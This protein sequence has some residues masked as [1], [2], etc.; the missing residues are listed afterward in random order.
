MGR[1]KGILAVKTPH[2]VG[3]T[4]FEMANKLYN[5][6]NGFNGVVIYNITTTLTPK[7]CAFGCLILGLWAPLVVGNG[8]GE[9]HSRFGI[10]ENYA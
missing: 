3:L 2:L 4:Y 8:P 9:A 5:I 1:N 6:N 7:N 10:R